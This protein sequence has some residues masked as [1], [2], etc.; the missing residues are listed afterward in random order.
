MIH[1]KVM[2]KRQEQQQSTIQISGWQN[3]QNVAGVSFYRLSPTLQTLIRWIMLLWKDMWNT[4]HTT[5]SPR[6]Y[7]LS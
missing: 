4:K 7:T 1:I 5:D 6:A 3:K 2:L